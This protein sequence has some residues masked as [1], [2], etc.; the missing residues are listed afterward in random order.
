M[1]INPVQRVHVCEPS[2]KGEIFVSSEVFW[3][4]KWVGQHCILCVAC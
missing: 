3:H 2:L 4:E 1:G